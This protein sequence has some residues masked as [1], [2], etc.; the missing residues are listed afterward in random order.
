MDNNDNDFICIICYE[1]IE[2]KDLY[3]SNFC[4]CKAKYHNNCIYK[5]FSIALKCPICKKYNT[6]YICDRLIQD[7]EKIYN[8]YK[9]LLDANY[10]SIINLDNVHL[11]NEIKIKVNI[12][13]NTSYLCHIAINDD[14]NKD[15]YN[16]LIKITYKKKIVNEIKK[17]ISICFDL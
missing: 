7:Y 17:F 13:H 14:I 8:M 16:E 15:V 2:I 6:Q 9:K 3:I 4:Q 1:E 5:H 10:L 12:F 11:S